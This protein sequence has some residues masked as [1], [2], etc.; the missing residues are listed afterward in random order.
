MPSISSHS[1]LIIGGS[2][3]IGHAVAQL[4]LDQ[5]AR[6]FI[7][8][9][10]AARISNAVDSIREKFPHGSIKGFPCDLKSAKVESNLE[11][12][13]TQ[14]VA[15]NDGQLLDHIVFTAGDQ[16]PIKPL[17]DID[18]DFIHDAGQVRFVAPLLVGKLAPRFL[19][20]SYISSFTLTGGMIARKPSPAWSVV[21]GYMSG[22]EG[23][24]K[25]LALDL[26]PIRVNLVLP[27]AVDTDL[28]GTLED[29]KSTME[30]LKKVSFQER[31]ASA[32]EVAESYIYLLR[33]TNATGS[34]VT[35]HGGAILI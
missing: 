8:S 31:V 12:L 35:T 34:T 17:T 33:D 23:M 26:K 2:S 28:W 21:A 19:K 32:A 6:V 11:K 13:L 24:T 4:T 27:G 5:N 10:N 25:N 9:S 30:M 7:S 29:R 3:G 20:Q 16:L 22:L 1:V 18:H 14:V 15:A